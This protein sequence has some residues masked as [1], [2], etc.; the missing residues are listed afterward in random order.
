MP[1]HPPLKQ[2]QQKLKTEGKKVKKGPQKREFHCVGAT[3]STHREMQGVPYAFFQRY[4][5]ISFAVIDTF[6][7][8]SYVVEKIPQ[9]RKLEDEKC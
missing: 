3:F 4:I 6:P 2:K 9:E 1:T 8:S 7:K 5:Y